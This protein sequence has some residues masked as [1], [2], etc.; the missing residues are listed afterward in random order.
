MRSPLP[1]GA[2]GVGTPGIESAV[3]IG[4]QETD[5]R[6]LGSFRQSPIDQSLCDRAFLQIRQENHASFPLEGWSSSQMKE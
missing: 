2:Q 6:E 4:I 1:G 3:A 5:L